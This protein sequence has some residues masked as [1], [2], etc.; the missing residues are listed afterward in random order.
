MGAVQHIK[1][2]R[3]LDRSQQIDLSRFE[4]LTDVT[5]SKKKVAQELKKVRGP[6][7]MQSLRQRIDSMARV[8]SQNY[9]LRV[10]PSPLNQWGLCLKPEAVEA[11]RQLQAGEISTLRD[12]PADL[13]NPTALLYNLNDVALAK[14]DDVMARLR[15]EAQH[16]RFTDFRLLFEGREIA[17]QEKV[18]PSSFGLVQSTCEDLRVYH[19]FCDES[20]SVK[21]RI[22][23]S[24]TPRLGEIEAKI[25][26]QPL[27]RQLG[28]NLFYGRWLTNQDIPGLKST[29]VIEATEALQPCLTRYMTGADNSAN[30]D[31]FL[32]EIVPH[33]QE[34]EVQGIRE[35]AQRL[36]ACD[37][38]DRAKKDAAIQRHF[39]RR[40]ARQVGMAKAIIAL[41][42]F[43]HLRNSSLSPYESAVDDGLAAAGGKSTRG[44][45]ATEVESQRL[46]FKER[47][48]G[49]R[50]EGKEVG[51]QRNAV[52]LTKFPAELQKALEGIV[53]RLPQPISGELSKKA[54]ASINTAQ[55]E[56]LQSELPVGLE[57]GKPEG[58]GED[59]EA[60]PYD[61]RMNVADTPLP[62]EIDSMW[63]SI[64]NAR[65]EELREIAERKKSAEVPVD[66]KQHAAEIEKKLQMREL[67][68]NGFTEEQMADYTN[69]RA[70][71][72]SVTGHLEGFMEQLRPFLPKKRTY[73][74]GE[75][76]YVTGNEIDRRALARLVP[77][78]DYRFRTRREPVDS[79]DPR[80]FIALLIDNTRSM[81]GEKMEE[82]RKTGIFYARVAQEL[83]IPFVIKLF[84]QKVTTIKGFDQSYD[85]PIARIKPNLMY[86]LTASEEETN[87]GAPLEETVKEMKMFKKKCPDL[88]GAIFVISDG[89]ANAGMMEGPLQ[90]YI[91][92]IQHDFIVMNFNLGSR[93]EDIQLANAYFGR[94]NVVSPKTFQELPRESIRTLSVVLRDAYRRNLGIRS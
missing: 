32:D 13:F 70:F 59:A 12:L 22:K 40:I 93:P 49:L 65:E 71:E 47:D 77:L 5:V 56:A 75:E 64:E 34:M 55:S 43:L 19:H 57:L 41:R 58:E 85:D 89:G 10:L 92:Q 26:E 36:I 28:L 69:F 16:A 52:D 29:A 53:D 80:I 31:L 83:G 3:F 76:L 48:E 79:P 1:P 7:A 9:D 87:M 72:A 73:R 6:K 60:D 42:D 4:L 90:Q 62:E 66:E 46:A 11:V 63:E 45:I 30:F 38:A 18:L 84:G 91:R 81:D 37:I 68:R 39:L 23:E 54:V 33:V 61:E 86:S 74:Q 67:A 14:E 35:E 82:A 2:E 24:F 21:D 94:K 20:T 15:H 88:F 50:N 27:V 25:N 51:R 44:A 17:R 78:G 8:F